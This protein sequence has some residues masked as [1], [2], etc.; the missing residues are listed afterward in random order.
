MDGG[1]L[2]KHKWS[3][4]ICGLQ[5]PATAHQLRQT[6]CSYGCMSLGYKARMSGK[7]NPNFR[8]ASRRICVRCGC[9][10]NS[11]I[12]SRKYCTQR[13][14]LASRPPKAPKP[15]RKPQQRKL[16]LVQAKRERKPK[17]VP[18]PRRVMATYSCIQ[19][20]APFQACPSQA[21]KYCSYPCYIESGGAFRAGQAAARAKLRYG[22]KRDANH[23]ELFAVLEK[24][25]PV[26]DFSSLGCGC[27][28]GIALVKGRIQFFD[29]KNPK[30]G[31]GKRG[32]NPRQ[33]RWVLEWKGG[34]VYLIYNQDDAVNFATGKFDLVK[35]VTAQSI[36]SE[37]G[38]I[39]PEPRKHT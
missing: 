22:V 16:P 24:M 25:V 31:Y 29:I 33:K 37:I 28:D 7:N 12:Q 32:L 20:G 6:Y 3:C 21:R 13:C 2:N 9:E 26:M 1:F 30:T 39:Y 34:A 38:D 17:P 15:E 8:N 23:S 4:A 27:P 11:Y 36:A 5:K 35:C 18:K 19:C 10:Y 14:Y